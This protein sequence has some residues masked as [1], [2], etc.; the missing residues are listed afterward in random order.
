M[1]DYD[2]RFTWENR[3]EQWEIGLT[4]LAAPFGLWDR[5]DQTKSKEDL[6]GAAWGKEEKRERKYGRA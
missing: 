6:K 5:G 3:L 4:F 2:V 1:V